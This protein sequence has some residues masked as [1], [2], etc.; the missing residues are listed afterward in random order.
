M[1]GQVISHYKILEK[2]GEGGMGIVYKAQDTKLDRFVALKFLPSHLSQSEQEKSRFF[3]EAKSASALN[4]PNVCTIYGIDEFE[5]PNGAGQ[6]FI[7]MELV[8]GITLRDKI[9]SSNSLNIKQV[10]EYAIQIGEALHEAHSKGIIHRDIKAENIMVNSKNQIKVMDFGLAKLKGSLKLT[11][12]SSTIG[13]LAYMSPEQIQGIEADTRSDIFSYG[14]VLFEMTTGKMPFR[15]EHEAAIMYSIVNEEPE[16]AAKFREDVPPELLHILKKSLEKDPED[17]YQSMSEIIVD[18]RR[19][20]K[21]STRVLRTQEFQRPEQSRSNIF[22]IAPQ[23]SKSKFL[24]P[25]YLSG[26]GITVVLIIAVVFFKDSIFSNFAGKNDKKIIVVL[27]FENLG[28]N[29]KDYFVDG[30]TDEVTSRL[31]GL[32]ALKVIARSSAVQYKKTTKTLKQIGEELGVNY[33]LQGTVRWET[34]DGQTHVRV[35]PTLIKVE[36]ETQAWSVSMESV[37]SSAFKLQSDIASRVASAMDVALATT[38]QKSLETSLTENAEAY[39]YYLKAIEYSDRSVSKSDQEIAI[40]LM[41][42]AIRLDPKFAA[43]YAKLAK[44]HASMYWF[45]YDRSERRV[46]QSRLAGEKATELAPQLSES[47]EAMGWY[48]YHTKLDYSKALGEFSLALSY[49]P[50]NSTVYYGIAAVMRRQGNVRGSIEAFEKSIESNPRAADLI[51]QLGETQTLAREYEEAN[52]NFDKA[53]ELS[54]DITGTYQDKIRNLLSWKGDLDGSRRIIETALRFGKINES[55]FSI[56]YMSY[57]IELLGGNFQAV[58]ST[59][60]RAN[61]KELLNDQFGYAPTSLLRAQMEKIR[62]NES[63]AKKYYDSAIV[64][65][66]LKQKTNPSDERL[67]SGLGIAYAGLGRKKEAMSA[68]ERGVELLPVE[69]EAWRGS[70]RLYDLAKIYASVGEHEKAMDILERLVSIPCEVSV[71]MLKIEPWWNPLRNNKRFQKLVA[72]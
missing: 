61:T 6:Q 35:N 22:P 7:E 64:F 1:I 40:Q 20:K 72:G 71:P 45:F 51:R 4:H 65:I 34:V 25:K 69:K 11:R 46:E 8:D 38:E 36:D 63:L 28:P 66:H 42:R 17:R 3:Q 60:D 24:S 57:L 58:Q 50:S 26:I 2:L 43:A 27:P 52:R 67:Y 62:G 47:H 55:E 14:V 31:S 30:M 53:L 23:P 56:E 12:T 32:S 16:D 68:G 19:L 33:V 37:L 39:D 70:F 48:Y 5:G 44:I 9:A 21:E 15:G 49:R 29:D 10:V 13:T 41:D 54:P 59:M 18:L